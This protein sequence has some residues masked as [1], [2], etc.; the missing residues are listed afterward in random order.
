MKS[1]KDPR[2]IARIV[3]VMDLYRNFFPEDSI[4]EVEFDVEDLEL[5][6]Y[7]KKMRETIVAGVKQHYVEIDALI[8]LY[9]DPLKSTDLDN[10][11]LQIIRVAV[12]EGFIAKSVPPKVAVDEAIELT[13]DFGSEMISRKVGGILGKV[14]DS[15][16]AKEDR[17][18]KP[19][20]TVEVT[21]PKPE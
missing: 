16:V 4:E 11:Q 9:S 3:S 19:E 20:T 6:N 12:Y 2:H 5:G 1:L 7:S 13:R 15:L 21:E 14:F 17:S 10:L 8:D 18:Q